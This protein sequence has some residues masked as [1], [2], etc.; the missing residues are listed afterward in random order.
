MPAYTPLPTAPVQEY[1]DVK[2]SS[3]NIQQAV[4]EVEE[5]LHEEVEKFPSPCTAT[6]RACCVSALLV[7]FF[8]ASTITLVLIFAP[9]NSDVTVIIEEATIKY[10]VEQVVI[11][12]LQPL[13]I[14]LFVLNISKADAGAHD[15]TAFFSC[16]HTNPN[17]VGCISQTEIPSF[18]ECYNLALEDS[19][20]RTLDAPRAIPVCGAVS[21]EKGEFSL[22]SN[23]LPVFL[24]LWNFDE[25]PRTAE[26][27]FSFDDCVTC[28]ETTCSWGY[29]PGSLI[30]FLIVNVAALCC[31]IGCAL[32]CSASSKSE[33]T[34]DEDESEDI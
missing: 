28:E 6:A 2:K 26:L 31:C 18:D 1:E 9:T 17:V 13:E 23:E 25:K 19:S 4:H 30:I 10:G 29:W 27:S 11:S 34:D 14:E 7:W 20:I 15:S 22:C 33:D 8:V 12:E 5:E 16:L 3:V 24:S 32:A 21:L